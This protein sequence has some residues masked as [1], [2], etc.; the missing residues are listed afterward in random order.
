[1]LKRYIFLLMIGVCLLSQKE[2]KAQ[3][4][5]HAIGFRAGTAYELSYKRFLFYY[6]NVQQA[7]EGLI[8]FQL[9]EARRRRNAYVLEGLYHVHIDVGFDTRF[10]AFAGAGLYMGVYTEIARQP[11]FGGGFT[12]AIGMA[13]TFKYVPLSVSLDWKPIIGSPRISLTRG[14]LTLRYTFPEL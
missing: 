12:G 5:D 1:M 14:G 13:Y 7:I 4:Y 11:Y 9:D 2:A 10:S 6:P 3:Y 8:G